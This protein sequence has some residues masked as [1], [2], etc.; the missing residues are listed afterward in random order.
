MELEMAPSERRPY[1]SGGGE[2][3]VLGI[4]A[5]SGKQDLARAAGLLKFEFLGIW[6]FL[7]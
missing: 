1:Q 6:L 3:G 2:T 5:N 4:T 7:Q